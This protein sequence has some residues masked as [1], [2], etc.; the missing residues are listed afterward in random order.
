M[1]TRTNSTLMTVQNFSK[2]YLQTDK[3]SMYI[4]QLEFFYEVNNVFGDY[5]KDQFY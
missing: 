3:W 2:F 1:T 4:E 5:K